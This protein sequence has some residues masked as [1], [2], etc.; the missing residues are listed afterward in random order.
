VALSI[1]GTK[2][3]RSVGVNHNRYGY[4]DGETALGS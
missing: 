4:V 3:L 1:R 2:P